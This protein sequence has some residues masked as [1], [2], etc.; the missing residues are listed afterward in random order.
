MESLSAREGGLAAVPKL[1][2]W[3]KPHRAELGEAIRRAKLARTR[4][5]S[6]EAEARHASFFDG[7]IAALDTSAVEYS[8]NDVARGMRLPTAMS[9]LLAEEIGI[10]VGDGT[11]STK[12]YY[13]SVRG[14]ALEEDY[15]VGFVLPLY[16]QLFNLDLRLLRRPPVCG[17]ELGSK[18]LY[19]FKSQVLGL[20]LG[21]K[22]E[23]VTIPTQVL[24]SRDKEVYCA[25]MRGVFDTDGCVYADPKRSYPRIL[26][27]IKSAALIDEM[28]VLLG[29][30]G[31][32]ATVYNKYALTL[33]GY[34][35]LRKWFAEIG[36]H[37]PKHL[38]RK[39]EITHRAPVV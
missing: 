1:K 18:A 19:S 7:N 5:L 9:P 2:Q 13:F 20:P 4:L 8:K 22:V 6:S 32:F 30:M 35:M 39:E 25:F 17:F 28:R 14:S 34:P 24:E 23:R 3:T 33:N 31:F 11:L 37:N 27:T 38:R 16:K 12:K 10:H 26:I 21:E 15:Y 36:S 29:K